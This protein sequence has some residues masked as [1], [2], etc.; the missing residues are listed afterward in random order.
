MVLLPYPLVRLSG[1][2]FG[3]SFFKGS[4]FGLIGPTLSGWF[5]FV[6][7]GVSESA[8]P[9]VV[10]VGESRVGPAALVFDAVVVAA[11]GVHV[12]RFGWS[13]VGPVNRVIEVGV[14]GVDA[15]AAHDTVGAVRP[16]DSL[17]LGGGSPSGDSDPDRLVLSLIH[18]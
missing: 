9:L 17:L 3:G 12:E 7:V 15:T 13:A 1:S 5:G 16:D 6:G 10:S 4:A 8:G 2:A 11:G 18:I 14:D